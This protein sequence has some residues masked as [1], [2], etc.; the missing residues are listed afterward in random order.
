MISFICPSIRPK[1][2]K[3][4]SKEIHDDDFQYEII[5]IGPKKAMQIVYRQIVN[6]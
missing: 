6:L 3:F 4:I 1:Y 5:F 2:W